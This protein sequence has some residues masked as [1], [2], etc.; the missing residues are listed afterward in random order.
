MR[1]VKGKYTL[2]NGSSNR[3]KIYEIINFTSSLVK[4]ARARTPSPAPSLEIISVIK[5]EK[6]LLLP[7]Y[8]KEDLSKE[9]F[10]PPPRRELLSYSPP[11]IEIPFLNTLAGR[12]WPTFD[13]LFLNIRKAVRNTSFIIIKRRRN[14]YND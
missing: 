10:F 5:I 13:V 1:V 3:K 12:T 14:N 4:E 8:K 6:L 11:P 9:F 2:T 7:I